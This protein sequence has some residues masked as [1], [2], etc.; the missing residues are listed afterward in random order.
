MKFTKIPETAFDEIQLNAG[1]L[2]KEFTPESA[3]C[4]G[5]VAATSGGISFEATP[6]YTDFGE[7]ID[8]CPKNMKELK[9]LESWEVKMSGDFVTVTADSAKLLAG[10]ADAS[11]SGS[12]DK[13]TPRNDV[14]DADFTD[15]WLVGDYSSKNGEGKG[16]FV[17]IHMLNSL[18]TGGFKLQ[19]S[20]KSK[21]K[22]TFEFTGHYSMAEQT[23]VPFEIFIK[24]GEDEMAAAYAATSSSTSEKSE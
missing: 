17:A 9:K 20:D 19:T 24:A 16:G 18:S 8:N 1:V 3:E 10:A 6:T 7:D 11:K 2:L 12:V 4:D 22:M 15:L 13:I 14:T 23:R 21:G 5:I